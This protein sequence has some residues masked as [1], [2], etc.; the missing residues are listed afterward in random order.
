MDG[1]NWHLL[2]RSFRM[3]LVISRDY[4]FKTD[5]NNNSKRYK[6]LYFFYA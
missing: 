3:T 4:R 5:N 2:G 6:F 1:Y